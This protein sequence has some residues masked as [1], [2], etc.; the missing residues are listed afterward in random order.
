LLP[1]ILA[2]LL[3]SV[4]V[5]AQDSQATGS[6]KPAEPPGTSTNDAQGAQGASGAA[7]A[8][9]GPATAAP[10]S[11]QTAGQP[12]QTT[13]QRRTWDA[14]DQPPGFQATSNL[15]IQNECKH[16]HSFAVT[17][18]TDFITLQFSQ[19]VK[20]AGHSSATES[21]LFHTDGL[22]E[23]DHSGEITVTCLD[24]E[25]TPPCMQDQKSLWP[26]IRIVAPPAT[27][28]TAAPQTPPTAAQQAVD[29]ARA[30]APAAFAAAAAAQQ[31]ATDA[32]NAAAEPDEKE[33]GS[34][35]GKTISTR[36]LQLKRAASRQAWQDYISGKITAEELEERWRNLD[37]YSAL[38]KLR[39]ADRAARAK[40]NETA[41]AAADRAAAA[42]RAATVVATEASADEGKGGGG[43]GGGA[44]PGGGPGGGP[45]AGPGGGPGGGTGGPGGGVSVATPPENPPLVIHFGMTTQEPPCQ[46]APVDGYFEPTQGV[47]QDDTSFVDKPGKQLVRTGDITSMGSSA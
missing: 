38:E 3:F 24:C 33:L 21:V 9:A 20:V 13:E 47:W 30:A 44:G 23:G 36:D 35:E 5:W 8:T 12:S 41:Q 39:A 7:A 18:N 14:G 19:P 25:E 10:G 42:I 28:T 31:A 45:G 29:A 46:Y 1:V 27:N 11:A 34:S 4:A 32:A 40:L 22:A 37:E 17:D 43:N 16:T 15:T 2:A 6:T 26:H